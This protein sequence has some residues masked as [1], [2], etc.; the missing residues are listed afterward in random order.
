MP[1]AKKRVAQQVSKASVVDVVVSRLPT[2]TGAPLCRSASPR[3]L[4]ALRTGSLPHSHA[5]S[6]SSDVTPRWQ[7]KAKVQRKSK[8]FG[9][10]ML[11][12]NGS[13]RMQLWQSGSSPKNHPGNLPA[14]HSRGESNNELAFAK[15]T[16]SGASTKLR[17]LE[18]ELGHYFGLVFKSSFK[19]G[20]SFACFLFALA[21]DEFYYV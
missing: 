12:V 10:T 18:P 4:N 7:S 5:V 2:P 20:F 17:D 16:R 19:V 9:S 8:S 11:H 21:L 14:C 6:Q 1:P 15:R 13:R 3:A